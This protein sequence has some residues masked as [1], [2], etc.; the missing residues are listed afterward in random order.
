MK[1]FLAFLAGA[2][3]VTAAAV[4]LTNKKNQK[5]VLISQE[6]DEDEPIVNEEEQSDAEVNE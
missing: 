5:T 1:K 3:A 6:F 2:A 4:Y